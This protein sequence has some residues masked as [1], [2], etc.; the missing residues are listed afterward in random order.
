MASLSSVVES[1]DPEKQL[2]AESGCEKLKALS[3]LYINR[4]LEGS[5]WKER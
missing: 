5:S 4:A 1:A 3:E 2:I